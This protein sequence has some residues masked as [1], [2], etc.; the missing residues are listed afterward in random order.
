MPSSQHAQA[1]REPGLALG[2]PPVRQFRACGGPEQGATPDVALRRDR[3]G[4]LLCASANNPS[5]HAQLGLV[6]QLA[7]RA[8]FHDAHCS[9]RSLLRI[10]SRTRLE[11][12]QSH[13]K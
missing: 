9:P 13:Q 8:L 4:Q 1:G 11:G 10:F 3:V 12:D 5:T 7:A 6:G 2:H